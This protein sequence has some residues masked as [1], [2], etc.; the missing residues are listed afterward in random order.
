MNHSRRSFLGAVCGAPAYLPAQTSRPNVVIL[1]TDDQG[2]GDLSLHGNTNLETP[3]LDS[4]ARDGIQFTQ[5]HVSPVCSPT[6]SSLMTGRYCYRTGVVDTYLGRSLM[7]AGEVTL[8]ECL[9][10]EGYRTALFGKWHLGDNYPLRAIDQGF[11]ESLNC[12]GGGLTQPSDPPGNS[13]FD[14]V[15]RHNGKWEKR[16]G[17]CTD[18]FMDAA[19]EWIEANRRQPFFAYIATNAPHDPL[20]IDDSYVAPFRKKGLDEVTAKTYGMVKNVDDNAGRLLAKLREL[21]LEQNTIV[22]FLTDNGPQRDRFNGGMR[23]RKG[24]VYEGGIRVPLFLK[25]PARIPPG[26]RNATLTAHIDILPTVLEACRVRLPEGVKIDGRSL[27]PLIAGKSFPPRTLFFQWHRGEVPQPHRNAA[28]H[29]G[30]FKL[31]NGEELYDLK[32]DFAESRNIASEQPAL[33]RKLRAAYDRWFADVASTRNFVP[34]RIFLG[35][36]HEDPVTLTRQDWRGPKAGWD[37]ASVGYWEVDVQREGRYDITVRMAVLPA[38]G[39]AHFSLNGVR[40][41]KPLP[42]GVSE[43]SWKGIGLKA[44]AGRLETQIQVGERTFGAHYVDV[45]RA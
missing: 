32:L 13:Y 24:T 33:V 7:H 45:A 23:G 36:D 10:S 41:E 20:Q 29:D 18:I 6:R 26:R 37:A 25:W 30:R 14:P 8:A 3:H 22:M 5:F 19:L 27:L 44:G 38:D 12:T 2:W 17:Y 4:I 9:K 1:I 39:T 16:K 34:P 28:A 42:A 11:E 15:L 21:G 35:T 31:V 43:V 40:L